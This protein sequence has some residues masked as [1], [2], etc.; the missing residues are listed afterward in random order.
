MRPQVRSHPWLIERQQGKHVWLDGVDDLGEASNLVVVFLLRCRSVRTSSSLGK[1]IGKSFR[2][3]SESLTAT[4]S[5]LG[6]ARQRIYCR[7][8]WRPPCLQSGGASL[9]ELHSCMA[10][11]NRRMR[12][13][14][15]A[16]LCRLGRRR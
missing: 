16:R 7:T 14:Q 12:N 5:M 11:A 1:T 13:R 10:D 15:I 4:S 8:Y 9:V 6:G 2:R 3:K